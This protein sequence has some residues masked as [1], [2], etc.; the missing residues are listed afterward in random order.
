MPS[1]TS[2][3]SIEVTQENVDF[4]QYLAKYGKSYGTKEEFQFRFE[5]YKNNMALIAQHN[6]N[7]ENTFT[8]G[9]NKFA[10]YTPAEYKKRLGYKRQG[11]VNA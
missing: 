5:Q 11:Q 2:L 1:S 7:N 6:S 3:Y 10:D 8:V 9:T 4:A